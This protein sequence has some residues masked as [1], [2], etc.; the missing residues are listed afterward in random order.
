M[1]HRSSWRLLEN[2]MNVHDPYDIVI[3]VCWN[4][5]IH[6]SIG[7]DEEQKVLIDQLPAEIWLH[8]FRCLSE[9]NVQNLVFAY[10]EFQL[11][12]MAWE[13]QKKRNFVNHCSK[14]LVLC[15]LSFL[16]G[17]RQGSSTYIVRHDRTTHEVCEAGVEKLLPHVSS[18]TT[19]RDETTTRRWS[20]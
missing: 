16:L 12:Q 18:G 15:M 7:V 5:K 8:V 6:Q 3:H 2:C 1:E 19:R 4:K 14:V 10:P 20:G 9:Q 13:A 17:N 11:L